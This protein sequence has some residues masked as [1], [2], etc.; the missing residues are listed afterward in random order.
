MLSLQQSLTAGIHQKSEAGL[1]SFSGAVNVNTSK[2]GIKFH[3]LT[4]N[5]FTMKQVRL[6]F[7]LAEELWNFLAASRKIHVEAEDT[8]AEGWFTREELTLA[9]GRF[10]AEV[11]PYTPP[12]PPAAEAIL[13]PS[14]ETTLF[15]NTADEGQPV[16]LYGKS[17]RTYP[18]KIYGKSIP[19]TTLTSPALICLANSTCAN[20][21]WQH[22]VNA[23]YTTDNAEQERVRFSERDDVS[24]LIVVPAEDWNGADATDDLIRSYLHG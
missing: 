15:A 23:I 7:P 4:E 14:A 16:E 24:H 19:A 17:G 2:P 21:T 5:I 12:A 9:T 20:G 18:G 22:R 13:T 11:L 10:G 3:Y 1:S 8:I 6:Q